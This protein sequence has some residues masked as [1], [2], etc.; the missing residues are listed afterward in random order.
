MD[1]AVSEVDL[2]EIV[3]IPVSEHVLVDPEEVVEW[4]IEHLGASVKSRDLGERGV[5]AFHRLLATLPLADAALGA[6]AIGG[7][8]LENNNNV[9]YAWSDQYWQFFCNTHFP[10]FALNTKAYC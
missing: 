5:E 9:Y 2:L 4:E 7:R 1:A 8:V 3:Q 6:V 10:Y